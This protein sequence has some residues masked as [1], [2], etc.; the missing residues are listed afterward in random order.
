MDELGRLG[1][2]SIAVGIPTFMEAANIQRIARLVDEAIDTQPDRG[3][4]V[5]VNVDNCSPDDTQQL[6]KDC[7][8]RAPKHSLRT[9]PGERGKGRNL[10]LLMDFVL[11]NRLKGA[12]TVDADLRAVPAQW[13][14]A[15]AQVVQRAQPALAV[16]LYPRPVND[17]NLTDHVVVPLVM[18]L[19]GHAIRQPIGG[20]FAFNRAFAKSALAAEWPA[21]ALGFGVDVH[22]VLHAAAQ[23]AAIETPLTVGKHHA[24]RRSDPRDV[25]EEFRGKFLEVVGTLFELIGRR[26]G[27]PHPPSPLAVAPQ[28]DESRTRGHDPEIMLEVA[29]RALARPA[30]ALAVRDLSGCATIGP[31]DVDDEMWAG[32]LSRAVL[33]W[34]TRSSGGAEWDAFLA[35][36]FCRVA[37]T[38]QHLATETAEIRTARIQNVAN[39]LWLNLEG[40]R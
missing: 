5:I 19:T 32:I 16:P 10:R 25:E 11:R 36:F 37:T 30:I 29:S 13:I 1:G 14:S 17:G 38:Q 4:F 6:F 40:K 3:E 8:T 22:L 35:L 24:W 23:Q 33:T 39:H 34:P 9:S 18:V 20:D 27:A 21:T 12:I 31:L 28:L 7:L 26:P 2:P 15:M